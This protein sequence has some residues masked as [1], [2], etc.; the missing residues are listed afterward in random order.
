MHVINETLISIIIFLH[1]SK[2]FLEMN[3]PLSSVNFYN[4]IS[5]FLSSN[6]NAI[7][8]TSEKIKNYAG[9]CERHIVK[10]AQ[11]DSISSR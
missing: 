8:V 10:F 2:V 7:H 5:F 6:T 4:K 3:G 9:D 1:K 11:I